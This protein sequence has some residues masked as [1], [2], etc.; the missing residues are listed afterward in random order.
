MLK[1]I[2][3]AVSSFTLLILAS[4]IAFS[5]TSTSRITGTVSD[6][7]GAVVPGASVTAKNEATGATQTQATTDAG[8]FAFAS[9]PIGTYTV[10]IERTGFRTTQKT[11][12]VLE[13]NT[14]NRRCDSGN[15]R[16]V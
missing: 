15:G 12:N 4:S 3:S 6:S 1:S 9:L 2:S 11:G 14:P 8:L 16:G 13:I 10:T 5:Q 7:S